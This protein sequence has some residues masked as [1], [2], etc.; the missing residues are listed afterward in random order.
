[1]FK[2]KGIYRKKYTKSKQFIFSL[3]QIMLAIKNAKYQQCMLHFF[4]DLTKKK[5][6][7]AFTFS[8][9][10]E[11]CIWHSVKSDKIRTRNKSVF[12]YFSLS[13]VSFDLPRKNFSIH[14]KNNVEKKYFITF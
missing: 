6:R 7:M 14:L 3:Y 13:V 11:E 12:G 4:S 1:M 10:H 5:F 8:V 2:E 9:C